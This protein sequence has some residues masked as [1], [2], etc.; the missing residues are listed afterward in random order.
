[1]VGTSSSISF[2]NNQ[3]ILDP[4]ADLSTGLEYFV[5]YPAGTIKSYG[6]KY[7]NDQLIYSFTSKPQTMWIWGNNTSGTLG[8]NQAGGPPWPSPGSRSSPTQLPG[9][10]W[11]IGYASAGS[12]MA[13][14]TNGTLWAWGR[15]D[16][17][18]L[19]FNSIGSPS[20][21]G[22]SSPTQVGTDTTWGQQLN[23]LN[24]NTATRVIK[25]DGTLWTW[26]HNYYGALGLNGAQSGIDGVDHSSPV[27]VGTDTT[28][29]DI[30]GCSYSSSFALKT[31]GTFW[32][33]GYN[34]NG[35]LGFHAG[36]G[37]GAS[38]SS[39][40]QV[41]TETTWSKVAYYYGNSMGLKTDGTMW[42]WGQNATGALAQNNRT[43]YNSPV[44]IP[45]TDWSIKLATV[46]THVLALKE[47]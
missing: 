27:Q 5:T 38:R 32:S 41:G 22:I 13:V 46:G 10:E 21:N 37:P 45:G 39:P 1:M 24:V 3:V 4:A 18:Q 36:P 30:S 14:K 31:D 16:K 2:V 43:Q 23:H 28:W 42:A 6:D 34:N 44:Q 11:K 17:G 19:G 26:G 35:E 40:V 47:V 33:W 8:L 29:S 7:Q 9:T 12:G 20:A 15:N 25:T